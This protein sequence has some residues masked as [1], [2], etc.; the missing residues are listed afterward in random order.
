MLPCITIII[1]QS[2]LILRLTELSVE[3]K[4]VF[5]ETEDRIETVFMAVIGI[6]A[7]ALAILPIVMMVQGG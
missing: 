6:V 1:F 2:T 7:T 4:S 3:R 5:M